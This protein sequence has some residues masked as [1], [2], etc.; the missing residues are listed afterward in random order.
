MTAYPQTGPVGLRQLPDT[1]GR[2]RVT[3]LAEQLVVVTPNGPGAALALAPAGRELL[4]VPRDD[5][6]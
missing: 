6:P 3:L 5:E 1:D 2:W 4:V